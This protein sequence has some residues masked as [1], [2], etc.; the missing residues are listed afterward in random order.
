MALSLR[1]DLAPPTL[2]GSNDDF[3]AAAKNGGNHGAKRNSDK[4]LADEL[5]DSLLVLGDL[6][7]EVR[8]GCW[9]G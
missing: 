9:W 8:W 3:G 7:T 4:G 5:H 6:P 1:S 2:L